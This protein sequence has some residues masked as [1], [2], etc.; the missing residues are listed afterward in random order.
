MVTLLLALVAYLRAFF[1]SRHN[2]ALEAVAVGHQSSPAG[3]FCKYERRPL[4][5]IEAG[6]AR[7]ADS[8]GRVVRGSR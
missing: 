6:D 8:I 1:V 3:L 4:S 7:E 5:H 2:L